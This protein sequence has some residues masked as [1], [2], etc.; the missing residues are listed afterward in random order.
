[1]TKNFRPALTALAL[2]TTV[3]VA[4]PA[5]SHAATTDVSLNKPITVDAAA[6]F[7]GTLTLPAGVE[8]YA[9]IDLR[10]TSGTGSV[11]I[12]LLADDW[13][14]GELD[15]TSS[16]GRV[17][18]LRFTSVIGFAGPLQAATEVPLSVSAEGL[19]GPIGITIGG[20]SYRST[21]VADGQ[22]STVTLPKRGSV[23]D[24][25]LGG[26]L[27]REAVRVTVLDSSF[28]DAAQAPVAH[29][30]LTLEGAGSVATLDA[31]A[32][33]STLVPA[34]VTDVWT[35]TIGHGGQHITLMSPTN[36]HGTLTL[37]IDRVATTPSRITLGHP[38]KL[39]ATPGQFVDH[40]LTLTKPL[41]MSVSVRS[42]ATSGVEAVAFSDAQTA[43]TSID[44][45][46]GATTDLTLPKG[47]F[48]IRAFTTSGPVVPPVVTISR[49]G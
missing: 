28:A 27:P 1:M 5:T 41:T 24:L 8:P 37:R 34:L 43:L 10:R 44:L 9:T 36:D 15:T 48:T 4:A 23:A 38:F 3:L 14:L 40:Q 31:T 49:V 11:A 16:A 46:P 35:P 6:G 18:T 13:A 7:G 2:L 30:A 20:L 12:W 21:V 45:S 39:T 26:F 32:G 19:T 42:Q 25:T 33:S 47:T 17:Q 29:E 22:T